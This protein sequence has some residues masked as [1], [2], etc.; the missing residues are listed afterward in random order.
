M[1]WALSLG[2]WEELGGTCPEQHQSEPI[3]AHEIKVPSCGKPDVQG[4]F[5]V[6]CPY[7]L[8]RSAR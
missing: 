6:T 5:S 7:L 2:G 3:A 4:T 1:N 8:P